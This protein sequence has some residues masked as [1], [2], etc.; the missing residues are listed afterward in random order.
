LGVAALNV[1]DKTYANHLNFAFNNQADFGRVRIN[2]SGRNLSAFV[3]Y[4]F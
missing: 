1:F 4:A 2:D 3:Q